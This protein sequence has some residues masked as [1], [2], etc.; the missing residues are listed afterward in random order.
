MV[1]A[2]LRD[3]VLVGQFGSPHGVDGEIKLFSF[4]SDPSAIASYKPLLDESGKRE[5]AILGLRA[6]KEN[7]FIVRIGGV[8]GRASAEALTN[9]G[10]YVPRAALPETSEEEYYLA[11][12]VGLKAVTARGEFFGRISNVFNFGGGDIL[13]L[14]SANSGE[15]LLLPFKKEIFPDVDLELGRVTVL[16]PVESEVKPPPLLGH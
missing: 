3:R 16:L 2:M 14:A 10:L 1:R 7:M 15:I 9:A 5:F 8:C 4:T 12:L 6:Q 13:E 11:D